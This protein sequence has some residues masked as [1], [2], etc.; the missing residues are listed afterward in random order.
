MAVMY[1]K[2]ISKTKQKNIMICLRVKP[3]F[4][5]RKCQTQVKK[6]DN[7]LKAI[8]ANLASQLLNALSFVLLGHVFRPT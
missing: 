1:P 8:S 5:F 2:A 4:M 6:T 7:T 3:N